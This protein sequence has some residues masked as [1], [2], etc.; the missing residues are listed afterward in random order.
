MRIK[1]FF[2]ARNW[3]KIAV[4][5]IPLA[6]MGYLVWLFAVTPLISCDHGVER[7]DDECIG[8]TDGRVV[9]SEDLADVLDKIRQE[10][11]D[12]ER[13]VNADPDVHA[14]SIA[15]LVP[16][17]KPSADDE[18]AVVLRHELEG[19]HLAQLQANRTK[20]LGE[21]PLIRL[22]VANSGDQSS[23]RQ[24]VVPTLLAKVSGLERLVTVVVTGHSLRGTI[25]SID[26]LRTGGIPV[27]ASR[28][29]GDSLT[30]LDPEALANVR[31]GLARM[32]PTA[33][34]QAAAT[35]AYLKPTASRVLIVRD[36]NPKDIWLQSI[37]EAFRRT[38]EDET[39]KVVVPP[40]TYDSQLGGVANAMRGILRNICVQKPEV[41]YF[42]GRTPA[43]V[44]F[45]QALPGRPCPELAINV[46]AGA[47]AV[48]F[49]TKVSRSDTE[50]RNG[51]SANTSVR[52]T[53]QAHPE[54]WK[55]SLESFS[56]ASTSHFIATCEYCFNTLFPGE[57]LEDAGAIVGHDAIVTAVTAIRQGSGPNY[58]PDLITQWFKRL[59]GIDA[60]PGASGW[61][62]LDPLGNP[63]NKAVPILQVNPDGTLKFLELSSPLGPPCVPGT[64]P[65]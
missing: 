3:V 44:S 10:N 28:L 64:P 18:L 5:G 61:I 49:V 51:L 9:L 1:I 16:L 4:I 6:L 13:R 30:E 50:L 42:A 39:H 7:V 55:A 65:C 15:H 31:G 24:R 35:A 2:K 21:K 56:A 40:E 48:E 45:V 63:V 20:T 14:V 29:A 26:T 57:S 37:D 59:H 52:Y 25:E 53:G 34:D 36:T 22:L 60:I 33:S 17:P 19:A 47:D 27:V 38:F 54:S 12:V 32:A 23:Q 8:V 43:L 11:E 41:V 62:S 58:E 46:I